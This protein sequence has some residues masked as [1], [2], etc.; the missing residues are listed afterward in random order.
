MKRRIIAGLLILMCCFSLG[1]SKDKEETDMVTVAP[2]KRPKATEKAQIGKVVT[3]TT[4][5]KAMAGTIVTNM[6]LEEKIGQMFI[7]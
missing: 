5:I 6:T 1:C 7:N 3:D 4:E 2:T